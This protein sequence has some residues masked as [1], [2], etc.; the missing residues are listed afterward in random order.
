MTQI[1]KWQCPDCRADLE[2]VGVAEIK[3]GITSWT[4]WRCKN[5]R[6]DLVE[7]ENGDED[8]W[9]LECRGCNHRLPDRLAEALWRV[10]E[11]SWTYQPG[12][13]S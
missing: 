12:T 11:S 3:T 1:L 8:T 5:E 4:I 7:E 9:H 6:W 10:M 13:R 2:T